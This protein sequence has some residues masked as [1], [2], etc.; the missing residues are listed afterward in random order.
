MKFSAWAEES[1]LDVPHRCPVSVGLISP[2]ESSPPARARSNASGLEGKGITFMGR[3]KVSRTPANLQDLPRW[4]CSAPAPKEE[5]RILS[6]AFDICSGPEW[7]TVWGGSSGTSRLSGDLGTLGFWHY[8]KVRNPAMVLEL[9]I[10]GGVA[11]SSGGG[12]RP[13][14]ESEETGTPPSMPGDTTC[15]CTPFKNTCWA[16]WLIF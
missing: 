9:Q 8:P 12:R 16:E 4:F 6:P 7:D 3:G 10:G 11:E 13:R 2:L 1:G 15:L 14:G 5:A